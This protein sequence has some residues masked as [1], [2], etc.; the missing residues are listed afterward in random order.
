MLDFSLS[1]FL[2]LPI[3]CATKLSQLTKGN[4]ESPDCEDVIW[5]LPKGFQHFM[6]VG[7]VNQ[8]SFYWEDVFKRTE[9]KHLNMKTMC[10]Q[11]M[12]LVMD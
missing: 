4:T 3:I 8:Q 12:K 1:Y 6:T 5:K 2:P 11:F 9:R 10:I 7:I